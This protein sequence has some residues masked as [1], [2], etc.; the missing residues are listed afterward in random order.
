MRPGGLA[1]IAMLVVVA[2][3]GC[4]PY[5]AW[6]DP[7]TVFPAVFTPVDDL[8]PYEEI[9]FETQTWTPG[10][11]V[12]E[13]ALYVQKALFHR[14]GA[15][16]EEVIHFGQARPPAIVSGHPRLSLVGD[17]M[18]L[19]APAPGWADAVAP[20]LDGDLRLG[21]LET[22][23]SDLHPTDR[24]SLVRDYGLYAFN[25]PVSLVQGLPLDVLQI[26]NN[27]SLDVGPEGLAR[28]VDNVEGEGFTALGGASNLALAAVDD[29]TVGFATYTWGLNVEVPEGYD[30]APLG[31]V[32][33]GE[34]GAEV[35]LSRV[36][37]DIATLRAEGASHVVLLV[38]W[39]FEY[40][41]WPDPHLMQLGRRL[42]A[43]GADVVAGH[44]P[45]TP[46]PAELCAVNQPLSVPGV[47]QCS[48][49]TDDGIT[50]D[51]AVLYS[52][53]NFGTDLGTLP[54]Q[55]GIVGSVSLDPAGGVSGL[56]WA[57]VARVG[58]AEGTELQ[59]LG[60]LLED[61]GY[62]EEQAR[63][64]RLLGTRWRR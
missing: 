27:H 59:P 31:I 57:P 2:G 40:E 11:D 50:R 44:G 51:A 14:P 16:V 21:N 53:G 62:A 52:L 20:L 26:N 42:V 55:V 28:T 6:P 3:A 45:H 38:H 33:F 54:L 58:G 34:V 36:G 8:E 35:D 63:L 29:L 1:L 39:G 9:R 7:A 19:V 43:L 41:Y 64:D 23:L 46:Q 49:R 32:G 13:T 17:V 25:A 22:P 37:T 47:G 10:V 61:P 30:P 24:A 5:R 4:D 48:V 12:E 60:A 15:P 56:G 18:P